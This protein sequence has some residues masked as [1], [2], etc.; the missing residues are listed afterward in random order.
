MESLVPLCC[1]MCNLVRL[2][3]SRLIKLSYHLKKKD[4]KERRKD[5]TD[6][7]RSYIVLILLTASSRASSLNKMCISIDISNKVSILQKAVSI[8]SL[9][10]W[11]EHAQIFLPLGW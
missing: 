2:L 6:N 8:Q 7:S 5:V 9:G 4:R 10:L 1:L 3:F 11:F